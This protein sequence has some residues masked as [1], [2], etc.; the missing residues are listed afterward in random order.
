MVSVIFSV[1][2]VFSVAMPFLIQ[3]LLGYSVI[4]YGYIALLLGFGYFVGNFSNKF[5]LKFYDPIKTSTNALLVNLILAFV[6]LIISF[7]VHNNLYLLIIPGFL[8][9]F[10]CGLAFPNLMTQNMNIFSRN[11]GTASAIFG[12]ILG[13][14]VFITTTLV[15]TLKSNIT[16]L[17]MMCFFMLF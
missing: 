13:L 6:I 2:I 7:K 10:L 5:L 1:I 14:T 12:L 9:F 3:T 8:M 11:A 16:M 17:W 15:S 4:V